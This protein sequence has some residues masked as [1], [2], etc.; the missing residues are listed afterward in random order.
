M[1]AALKHDS[2]FIVSSWA[3]PDQLGDYLKVN[4]I[5][6]I[7]GQKTLLRR[8]LL[9]ISHAGSEKSD[10]DKPAHWKQHFAAN[11]PENKD[12]WTKANKTPFGSPFAYFSALLIAIINRTIQKGGDLNWGCRSAGRIT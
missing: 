11:L 10:S 1:S 2:N 12:Q 8:T 5:F 9:S 4:A 3:V 7:R 6:N